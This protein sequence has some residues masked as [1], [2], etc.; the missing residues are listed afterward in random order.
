MD[1]PAQQRGIADAL[2]WSTQARGTWLPSWSTERAQAQHWMI[3]PGSA[4]VA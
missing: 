3:A 2:N 4:R 1:L